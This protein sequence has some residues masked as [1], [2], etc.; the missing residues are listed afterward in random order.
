MKNL[1][2]TVINS[3]VYHIDT[4]QHFNFHQP[5]PSFAKYQTEVYDLGIK[6]F[7]GLPSY[8]KDASNNHKRFK[9]ILKDFY[10]KIN[11]IH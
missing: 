5:L 11:F 4:R 10:M 8:I 6:V 7:S 2:L 1:P 9:L 3:E